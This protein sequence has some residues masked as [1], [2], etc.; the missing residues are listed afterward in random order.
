VVPA[1]RRCNPEKGRASE[2]LRDFL[3]VDFSGRAMK[4]TTT[5]EGDV[6][7]SANESAAGISSSMIRGN[8][9]ASSRTSTSDASNNLVIGGTL[10]AESVDGNTVV[11]SPGIGIEGQEITHN[12]AVDCAVGI[13][14]A[15]QGAIGCNDVWDCA[16]PWEGIEDQTGLNGN[17]SA[18]PLFCNE[19]DFT[20]RSDSPCLPGNHPDGADCGQIGAR[21]QG[22]E[23]PTAVEPV[24]WGK[25]KAAYR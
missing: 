18:D 24:T 4:A 7:V 11:H 6:D 13:S 23:A 17:F 16:V 8:A 14:Q 25:L 5:V 12:L 22:C 9:M 2:Y 3:L 10:S 15:G 20:L 1:C 21:G 19:G